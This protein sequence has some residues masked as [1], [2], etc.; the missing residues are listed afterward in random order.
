[1]WYI[2]ERYST[3]IHEVIPRMPL[4]AIVNYNV[5]SVYNANKSTQGNIRVV[6]VCHSRYALNIAKR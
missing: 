6:G 1:L 3:P 4:A 2:F 5:V